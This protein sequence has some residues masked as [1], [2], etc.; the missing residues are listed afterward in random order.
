MFDNKDGK[1]IVTDCDGVLFDWEGHFENWM[2]SRGYIKVPNYD[3]TQYS[4]HFHYGI[5]KKEIIEL[6]E[7][8]NESSAIGFCEPYLDAVEYVPKLKEAGYRFHVI[9]SLSDNPYSGKAR[10]INLQHTFGD[11]FDRL[12]CLPV[13]ADKDEALKPYK[14]SRAFWIEDKLSNAIDGHKIGMKALLMKQD[15]NDNSMGIPVLHNWKEIYDY[16]ISNT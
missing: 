8:F 1:L 16:I 11:I 10:A 5:P 6:I 4:L 2:N 15:H 7:R 12:L 13:G 9:T 3:I 14:G